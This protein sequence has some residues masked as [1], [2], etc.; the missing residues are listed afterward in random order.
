MRTFNWL[1]AAGVFCWGIAGLTISV[2]A[3]DAA[4]SL[5]GRLVCVVVGV[6]C[7]TRT[8]QAVLEA[9]AAREGAGR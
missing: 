4:T 6:G 5:T 8:L 7:V 1:A 9:R 2:L 3:D